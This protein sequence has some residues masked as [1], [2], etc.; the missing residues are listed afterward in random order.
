M[1]SLH[2]ACTVCTTRECL[3]STGY[4][5]V[6][7]VSPVS[8]AFLSHSQISVEL[9]QTLVRIVDRPMLLHIGIFA[10]LTPSTTKTV[11]TY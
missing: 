3:L 11:P 4:L 2:H 7:C 5:N 10:P 8:V 6:S 9:E 1:P